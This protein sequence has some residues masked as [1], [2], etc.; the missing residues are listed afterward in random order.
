MDRADDLA[1]VI[2]LEMGRP[3]AESRGEVEYAADY[4][5][6]YAEEAVRLNGR[7]TTS[8]DGRSRIVTGRNRWG[9]AC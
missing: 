7:H 8:P 2:T 6:W 5:R 1:M 4:I 9:P 3:L